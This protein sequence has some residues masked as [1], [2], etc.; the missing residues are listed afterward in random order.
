MAYTDMPR[1]AKITDTLPSPARRAI[2]QLGQD[3][4]VARRRR[5]VS[6]QLMADRMLV[7]RE[8]VNRLERGDPTVSLS[9]LASAMFVLGLTSRLAEL[10]GPESDTV[11][12][13]EDLQRLPRRAHAART[14]D[15]DF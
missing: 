10:V 8:T 13:S 7:T 3:L 11:G 6:Q 9:V 2:A 5:R 4:A 12:M 14:D 15:L 1:R